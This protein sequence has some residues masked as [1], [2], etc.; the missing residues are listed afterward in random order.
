VRERARFQQRVRVKSKYGE[1]RWIEAYG[2]PWYGT[3]EQY[4]G[5]VFVA[6]D[7]TQSVQA[8]DALKEADRRKDEF[9]ATLAHELRNPLAPICNL[10]PLMGRPGGARAADRL[11]VVIQRQVQQL[12]RLVDDLMEVSRVTRGKIALRKTLV[13]LADVV[14][15]AIEESQPLLDSAGHHLSVSVPDD[16]LT[17]DADPVRLTQVFANLINNAGRYTEN[18]G[19]IWLNV[20]QD[21]NNAVV[22]VRDN[23]IGI[24]PDMLPRVFEMFAQETRSSG[25]SQGGLGIG[26]TLVDNLVRMHG[27]SVEAKS[28]GLGKGSEFIVRLPLSHKPRP[29]GAQAAV[30]SG[31]LAERRVLVVDDNP[32][33]A[34]SLAMLLDYLGADTHVVANGPAALAALETFGPGVVLMDIGMPGMSG[35]EVAQRIREQPKFNDVK[36]IAVTGWGQESDRRTS[37]DSGFDHHL[38]KPV[39]I[40][41]LQALLLDSR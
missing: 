14:R 28:Q 5:H 32:D 36:L 1:W 22:S 9:L 3:G 38:T 13:Q 24:G 30:P 29:E 6:L 19:Q 40:A 11:Q 4:A 26:L 35:H 10:M 15:S 21:K 31:V 16:T 18:G 23:G 37:H 34:E 20:Y 41:E 12:V 17:L 25:R 27:G 2:L 33:A 7:I 39:D 8:E